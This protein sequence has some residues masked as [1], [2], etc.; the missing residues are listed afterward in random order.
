MKPLNKGFSSLSKIFGA[1]PGISILLSGI[2]TPPGYQK[3]FG[4]VIEACGCFVLFAIWKN[5]G[6]LLRKGIAARTRVAVFLILTSLLAV[7]AYLVL[8]S[9]CIVTDRSGETAYFPLWLKGKLAE[10]VAEYGSR[11]KVLDHYGLSSIQAEANSQAVG[12]AITTFILLFVYQSIFSCLSAAFG[13]LAPEQ[14]GTVSP[15]S[16]ESNSGH[17]GASSA[18]SA[19]S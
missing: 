2:G 11:D 13:I 9:V 15:D 7:G 17:T 10:K 19:A 16:P 4:G 6:R 14:I 18:R 5:K 1:L 3:L 8:S 12:L